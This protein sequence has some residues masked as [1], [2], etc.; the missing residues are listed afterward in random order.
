LTIWTPKD[1]EEVDNFTVD[2]TQRLAEGET[3]EA[4]EVAL[5]IPQGLDKRAVTAAES[6]VTATLAAGDYGTAAEL[7]YTATTNT[8]RQFV[9]RRILLI[10][11]PPVLGPDDEPTV[12]HL[13]Q[14]F[15][16]FYSADYPQAA[17]FL[18][19]AG[20]TVKNRAEYGSDWQRARMLL[21]AHLMT[22]GGIG[23]T[24]EASAIRDGSANFRS[25]KV[26]SL[27][28][29][30]FDAAKDVAAVTSTRY[31]Q[32][33]ALIAR[34]VRGGARVLN[35]PAAIG[36]DGDRSQSPVNPWALI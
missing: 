28:L 6:V 17:Y 19:R 29:D 30:R 22:V 9:E 31:G 12:A 32:E 1:P 16:E 26:G 35:M 14:A 18:A 13:L 27:Q 5:T 2:F 24:P 3:I 23:D 34:A 21:A 10:G 20:Q 4:G 33:F 8:G 7:K 25:M 36:G 15:P 11:H